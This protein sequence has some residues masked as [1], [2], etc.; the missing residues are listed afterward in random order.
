MPT[1]QLQSRDIETLN[2]LGDVGLLD[3]DTLHRRMFPGVTLRR[4][5][6]KFRQYAEQGFVHCHRLTVWYGDRSGRVPTL[7][8]L[9]ERGAE[10]IAE[11]TGQ[12]PPRVQRG[13]PKP[14]TLHHRLAVSQVRLAMDDGFRSL[15]LAAPD[16]IMEYDR[17]PDIDPQLTTLH[18]RTLYHV[19]PGADRSLT[20]LPDAA[21][22]MEIPR[23]I[24]HPNAGTIDL[25]TYWEVDRSTERRGQ[26]LG[27]LPGL[28]AVIAHRAWQRYFSDQSQAP[29]RVFFVC[30]SQKRIETLRESLRDQPVSALLRFATL[31]EVTQ[32]QPVTEPIWR[33]IAGHP[34]EII[35]CE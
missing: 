27:K 9:T 1:I 35:R 14:E 20:Y 28:S 6:Q 4:C 7:F 34:R 11:A 16:W 23:D 32:R 8:T 24:H 15:G 18:Q 25:V 12:R 33:D 26:V 21:C 29:V 19:L 5:Q 31:S 3:I 2:L 13:E 22:R 30:L 17:R 10:A